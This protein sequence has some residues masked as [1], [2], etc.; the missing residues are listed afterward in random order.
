M[1]FVKYL[2][3]RRGKVKR[4]KSEDGPGLRDRYDSGLRTDRMEAVGVRHFEPCKEITDKGTQ[5][6]PGTVFIYVQEKEARRQRHK[7][8]GRKRKNYRQGKLLVHIWT[9]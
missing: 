3:Y 4:S 8:L 7:G 1:K 9:Y 6:E 5:S 2:N